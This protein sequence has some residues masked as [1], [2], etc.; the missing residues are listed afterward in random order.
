LTRIP[1][2][3]R[4]ASEIV[5]SPAL[6]QG[7]AWVLALGFAFAISI[8]ATTHGANIAP[9]QVEFETE[10]GFTINA[11]L[12]RAD[13]PSAPAAILL[14]MY[15]S[16]RAAWKPLVPDLAAAG[17]TVL[18]IDQR[19]HGESTKRT[20]PDGTRKIAVGEISRTAFADVVRAGVKDV[21]A[22]RSFLA[23]QGLTTNRIVLV[24]A[25]Y[26][27]TVSL[28][29]AAAVDDVRALVLLSPGTAY[30]GVN[31]VDQARR[32][33]GSLLAVAA[34]DDAQAVKSA[35]RLVEVHGGGNDLIVYPSG[36]HGTRL[37]GPRPD[38][39]ERI[40]RFL[41]EATKD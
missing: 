9:A 21:A 29:S 33:P 28:L 19:A 2:P 31:V 5:P 40:V 32:F 38:V 30:F 4:G 36:G 23:T 27:C 35:R 25:S 1:L 37:F 17:F 18:A 3:S 8:A 24:G 12:V 11:D 13:D 39:R 6:R 26:G 34:E 41:T 16:N 22:A 15:R 10:D 14:H 7:R 20:G